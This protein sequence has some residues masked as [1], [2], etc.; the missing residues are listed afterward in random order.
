MVDIVDM[1]ESDF[2][3][4]VWIGLCEGLNWVDVLFLGVLDENI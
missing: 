4:Y 3:F 2:S 1:K